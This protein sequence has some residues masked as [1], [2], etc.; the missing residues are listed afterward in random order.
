MAEDLLLGALAGLLGGSS[1]SYVMW[2]R[3]GRPK[4]K[5]PSTGGESSIG[6]LATKAAD[7]FLGGRIVAG[8]GIAGVCF[9]VGG[10]GLLMVG[11]ARP[12]LQALVAFAASL[13]TSLGV[14]LVLFS[15]A[16]YVFKLWLKARTQLALIE[17]HR[18]IAVALLRKVKAGTVNS[19]EVQTWTREYVGGLYKEL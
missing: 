12:Q 6:Q 18:E 8:V 14:L 16:L 15:G 5:L 9:G 7:A 19:T 2:R 17:A 3:W 4:Q 10:V 11:V 13:V 1:V